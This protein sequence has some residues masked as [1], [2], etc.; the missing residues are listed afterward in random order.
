MDAERRYAGQHSIALRLAA[1]PQGLAPAGWNLSGDVQLGVE[2][3]VG[4]VG[5]AGEH[6]QL[7]VDC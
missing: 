5:P 1:L 6:V 2:R 4:L 3:H 7:I